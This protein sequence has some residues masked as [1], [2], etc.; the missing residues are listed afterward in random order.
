[1]NYL[2]LISWFILNELSRDVLN[3]KSL[4]FRYRGVAFPI[5]MIDVRVKSRGSGVGDASSGN[6]SY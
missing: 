5:S 6:K 4:T 1:M 3:T 2:K